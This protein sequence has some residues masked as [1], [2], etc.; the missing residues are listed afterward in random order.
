MVEEREKGVV[1][2]GIL[3]GGGLWSWS[4]VVMGHRMERH[5]ELGGRRDM[6]VICF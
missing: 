4:F 1:G 3:E 2:P 6:I 5:C